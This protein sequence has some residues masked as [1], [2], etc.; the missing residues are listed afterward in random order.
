MSTLSKITEKVAKLLRQAEDQ[1]GTPEGAIF[2]ARAFEIMSK[3]GVEQAMVEAARAG[4]DDMPKEAIKWSFV[5]TGKYI[6]MQSLLLANIVRALH[7]RAVA[8]PKIGGG[9][10]IHVFGMPHHID[11]VKSLYGIL[12]PQMLRL[13]ETVKPP[14]S[15]TSTHLDFDGYRIRPVK[16]ST[17]S[18]RRAWIAGFAQSVGDRLRVE[19]KKA[20]EAA[21]AGS[22][23]VLYRG[24]DERALEAQRKAFPRTVAARRSSFN[25][26]GYAHGQRDGR[27]AS[28]SPALAGR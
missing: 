13:V 8:S 23:L 12:R 4:I 1:E 16:T 17:V 25:S 21:S 24:D 3:Y 10:E 5:N 11:R 27:A 14:A 18:Y 22:A 26:S 2:M 6:P 20:V 19:E 15:E 7:C 9:Q 28:F